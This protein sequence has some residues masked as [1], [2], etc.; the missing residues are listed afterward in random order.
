MPYGSVR[1]AGN[2]ISPGILGSLEYATAVAGSVLIVV[3]GHTNCGAIKGACDNVTM[4]H[5]TSLLAHIRP[6]VEMER[7]VTENRTSKNTEF[8]EKV[9]R[10][11][12]K[13]SV[14]QILDESKIIR[15]LVQEGKTGIIPAM[16]DV[17]TGRVTFFTEGSTMPALQ[18]SDHQ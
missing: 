4:G 10:I 13:N 18:L 17:G 6:A 12:V 7:S 1:I 11:N 8:V 16:Y 3:L 15:N 9:T 2:I 5:L 14:E